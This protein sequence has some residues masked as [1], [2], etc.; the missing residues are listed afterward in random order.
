MGSLDLKKLQTDLFLYPL[1][2]YGTLMEAGK[3][4]KRI[5]RYFYEKAWVY[6][7]DLH[8][9]K[10]PYAADGEGILYG[11]LYWNIDTKKLHS[12]DKL[13]G[14]PDEYRRELR[15]VSTNR[16]KNV[17]AWVYLFPNAKDYPKLES[18]KYHPFL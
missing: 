11:E 12:L 17:K 2:V 4:H 18:G 3:N 16:K 15:Y 8:V 1:L 6:K 13:E 14:H 7:M 10:Y 9:G 5:A